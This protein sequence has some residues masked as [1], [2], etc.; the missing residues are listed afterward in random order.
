MYTRQITS[1]ETHT[2]AEARRIIDTEKEER[3]EKILY[4]IRQKIFGF[5]LI[6]IAIAIA[7]VFNGEDNTICLLI[8]PLGCY[9]LFTKGKVIY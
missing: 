1:E 2:L 3:R 6:T 7:I 8:V 4:F 5:L 9:L